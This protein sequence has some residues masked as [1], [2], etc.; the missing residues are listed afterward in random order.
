[1]DRGRGTAA[2]HSKP[3]CGRLFHIATC[4]TAAPTSATRQFE[5]GVHEAEPDLDSYQSAQQHCF[6]QRVSPPH[7]FPHPVI[8]K[9]LLAFCP[10][11]LLT[12]TGDMIK[13]VAEPIARG[14]GGNRRGRASPPPASPPHDARPSTA[15]PPK[16][17]RRPVPAQ[18]FRSK[19]ACNTLSSTRCCPNRYGPRSPRKSRCTV[20][21]HSSPPKPRPNQPNLRIEVRLPRE[22]GVLAHGPL[23]DHA[24]NMTKHVLL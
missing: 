11:R 14:M 10:P 17:A 23:P 3:Q 1:M 15:A 9:L 5:C 2:H 12:C 8:D 18:S 20:V 4:S 22:G 24:K 7:A 19:A 21:E 6:L 16:T 13:L